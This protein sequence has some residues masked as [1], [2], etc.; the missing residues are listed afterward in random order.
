MKNG[1]KKNQSKKE[2]GHVY[3]TS[4]DSLTQLTLK[5]GQLCHIII[6]L[7]E[8]SFKERKE[9]IS[10]S[11]RYSLS[12]LERETIISFNDAEK[13]AV[14]YTCNKA[15]IRK[16]DN[17]LSSRPDDVKLMSADEC[18]KT[19]SLPKQWVKVSPPR[20]VSEEQRLAA[21]KRMLEYHSS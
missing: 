11:G 18:S 2:P 4:P 6:A 1:F 5:K 20:T 14:L 12:S 13:T 16:M 7:L 10:M 3:Q 9:V 8:P 19:Y 15:L 21:R 17:Y